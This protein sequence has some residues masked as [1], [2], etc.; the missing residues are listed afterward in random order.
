MPLESGKT[1]S[2]PCS[3][4]IAAGAVPLPPLRL[5][6]M[7]AFS[8]LLPPLPVTNTFHVF[9]TYWSEFRFLSYVAVAVIVTTVSLTTFP[10]ALTVAVFPLPTTVATAELLL[11]QVQLL[12]SNSLRLPQRV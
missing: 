3:P 7:V 9:V 2:A 10:L 8:P 1:T 11:L 4:V 12:Y 5:K 6:V